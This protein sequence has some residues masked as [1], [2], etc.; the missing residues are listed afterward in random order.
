LKLAIAALALIALASPAW[1]DSGALPDPS[2][3]PG[4]V[5][6]VD[7]GEICSHGTRELRHWSRERDDRILGEYGLPAG[8]HPQYEIDHL[9]PLELG[10]ADD[11]SNLWP[12]QRRSIEPVYNA[13]RKDELENRLARLVCSHQLDVREAQRL[14]AEDWTSAFARFFPESRMNAFPPIAGAMEPR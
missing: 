2:L 5:R 6:T 11:D 9:I 14:I 8:P 1:A 10:G 3:T 7:V 13:E 4:A 12:E